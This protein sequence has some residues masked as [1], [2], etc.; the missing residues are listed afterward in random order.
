[1]L[2]WIVNLQEGEESY[3]LYKKEKDGLID[4]LKRRAEMIEGVGL[5]PVLPCMHVY[6]DKDVA[7]GALQDDALIHSKC[8]RASYSAATRLLHKMCYAC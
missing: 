2:S 6:I 7:C 8:S 4:S 1:M 3:P 5:Q